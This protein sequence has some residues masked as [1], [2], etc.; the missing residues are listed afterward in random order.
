MTL[1]QLLLELAKLQLPPGCPVEH[2]LHSAEADALPGGAGSVPVERIAHEQRIRFVKDWSFLVLGVP[3]T[4]KAGRVYNVID[5]LTWNPQPP[6][7][8]YEQFSV[9]V[10]Y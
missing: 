4:V 6:G 3:I 1:H 2:H 5:T 8:A 10:I 7:D 9:I